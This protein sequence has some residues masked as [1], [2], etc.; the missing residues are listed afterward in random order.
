MQV[1]QIRQKTRR[2]ARAVRDQA[3]A[4]LDKV[5]IQAA[6]SVTAGRLNYREAT[7]RERRYETSLVP[8]SAEVNTAAAYAFEKGSGTLLLLLEAERNDNAIRVAAVQA[9]A[10]K[11][12]AAIALQAALGRLD[13]KTVP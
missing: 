8:R 1:R 9:L 10:D 11:V 4:Q 5:R 12:S 6:A 2:A 3:E 13:P 7:E